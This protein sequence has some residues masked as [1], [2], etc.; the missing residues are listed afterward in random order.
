MLFRSVYDFLLK[1]VTRE[2]LEEKIEKFRRLNFKFFPGR[3]I[4]MVN[5]IPRQGKIKINSRHSYVLINPDQM[6]YCE[7]HDGYSYMY[8][9]N[10]KKE[11][12]GTSLSHIEQKVLKWNFFR[13]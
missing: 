5:S 2:E 3:V 7:A 8:L 1:P 10:G 11:V 12:A 4:E 9:T 6:L 13:L